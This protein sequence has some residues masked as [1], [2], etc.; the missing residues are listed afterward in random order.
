MGP[1]FCSFRSCCC[2]YCYLL[3]LLLLLS[4]DAA[5]SHDRLSFLLLL[6]LSLLSS[7]LLSLSLLFSLF[8][9]VAVEGCFFGDCGIVS[10]GLLLEKFSNFSGSL[11]MCNLTCT[12]RLSASL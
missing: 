8:V 6:L 5:M 2:R 12:I 7:L 9:V 3:L 1:S 11:Q 10:S 4:S